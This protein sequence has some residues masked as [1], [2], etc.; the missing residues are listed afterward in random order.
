MI[1]LLLVPLIITFYAWNNISKNI[2]KKHAAVFLS[3]R[4]KLQNFYF[5]EFE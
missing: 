3:K 5:L 2:K 4:L 1:K